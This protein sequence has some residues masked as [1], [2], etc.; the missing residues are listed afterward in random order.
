MDKATKSN[1]QKKSGKAPFTTTPP[2]KNSDLKNSKLVSETLLECIRSEDLDSFQSILISCLTVI[3]KTHF[4]KSAGI[5]RT[6][7]YELLDPKKG[8]PQDLHG[9]F[10]PHHGQGVRTQ[11]V[12]ANR[13]Q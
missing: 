13:S 7:L 2:S 12:R 5:G 6:T 9:G 1:Q 3:N 4:A 8:C 11:I 10:R